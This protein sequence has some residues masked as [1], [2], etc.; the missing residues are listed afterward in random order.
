[1]LIVS[2]SDPDVRILVDPVNCKSPD[3]ST[4]IAVESSPATFNIKAT[5]PDVST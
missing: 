2:G 5:D 1:M 3:D 4:V